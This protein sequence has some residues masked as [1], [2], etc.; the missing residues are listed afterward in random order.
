[1]IEPR[2]NVIKLFKKLN[3]INDP[4]L[5][6]Y[7]N[8]CYD[9][10]TEYVKYNTANHHVLPKAKDCFPEYIKSKWN[11]VTL[12]HKD[13][14]KAHYILAQAVHTKSIL[15]AFNAMSNKNSKLQNFSLGDVDI[16]EC[17]E[18]YQSV[19]SRVKREMANKT[20]GTL[21][22]KCG[23]GAKRITIEEYRTGDYESVATDK[24]KVRDEQ[25]D[26]ITFSRKEFKNSGYS[27][28][29][30][31][32]SYFYNV[33]A[34]TF[35]YIE[36]HNKLNHIHFAKKIVVLRNG[37]ITK[38]TTKHILSGDEIIST[39]PAEYDVF[40]VYNFRKTRFE[41]IYRKDFCART[42]IKRKNKKIR[43]FDKDGLRILKI[44]FDDLSERYVP[45][46]NDAVWISTNRDDVKISESELPGYVKF[47]ILNLRKYFGIDRRKKNKK[48]TKSD[49]WY[50]SNKNRTYVGR[51]SANKNK[52]RRLNILTNKE[53]FITTD[54]YDPSIHV[55]PI[56][57]GN[58]YTYEVIDSE[59]NT[60]FVGKKDPLVKF[61][62]ELGIPFKGLY[63]S[64]LKN[65]PYTTC[66]TNK[67]KKFLNYRMVRND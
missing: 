43:V 38:I 17:S 36:T 23:S 58:P 39:E 50:E 35:E 66:R 41:D 26:V 51:K 7:V 44:Q 27:Y 14:M 18:T 47:S 67:N 4:A 61:C 21:I 12:T 3:V 25:G 49:A 28:H 62:I 29:S 63:N 10:Q 37:T 45:L 57:V 15:F 20:K 60:I 5:E 33:D 2:T 54:E 46:F 9:N 16:Q 6:E 1:M 8:F 22:V 56:V 31:N 34:R 32:K 40:H 30:L 65:E 24:V 64:Y 55:S 11:I 13:H 48:Y 53:E 52:L 19:M 42:H 59:G